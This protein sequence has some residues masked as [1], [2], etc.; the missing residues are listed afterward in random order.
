MARQFYMC[1]YCKLNKVNKCDYEC[2]KRK[3]DCM[4]GFFICPKF[5]YDDGK[6]ITNAEWLSILLKSDL[7]SA[8]VYVWLMNGCSTS[9]SDIKEWLNNESNL[10]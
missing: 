4:F 1:D 5:I 2:I 6:T 7:D 9:N 10:E 3:E 8:A